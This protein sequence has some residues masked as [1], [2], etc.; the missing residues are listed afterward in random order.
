VKLCHGKPK[1]DGFSARQT[2]REVKTLGSPA[3]PVRDDQGQPFTAPFKR[4]RLV[5]AE[6]GR[7]IVASYRY[8]DGDFQYSLPPH[9]PKRWWKKKSLLDK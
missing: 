7:R 6:C 8:D 4:E 2:A 3:H 9:K 5:C 1:A